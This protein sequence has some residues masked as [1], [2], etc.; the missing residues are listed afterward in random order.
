M[1]LLMGG[2]GSIL[3]AIGIA[4][5]FVILVAL[6]VAVFIGIAVL[7]VGGSTFAPA[8][9]FALLFTLGKSDRLIISILIFAVSFY[10][11]KKLIQ[12]RKVELAI[13]AHLAVVASTIS[14]YSIRMAI[15]FL[16]GHAPAWILFVL[17]FGTMFF[18]LT[19]II[20]SDKQEGK[21]GL[22]II[23]RVIASVLYG[24]A[25]NTLLGSLVTIFEINVPDSS[26]LVS[27]IMWAVFSVIAYVLDIKLAGKDLLK[28]AKENSIYKVL[29]TNLEKYAEYI[30][31]KFSK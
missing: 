18:M 16:F 4:V 29:S 27:M 20:V 2:F 24:S 10:V 9:V 3:A 13:I 6:V 22:P 11:I 1:G 28:N 7:I 25:F 21:E 14:T 12:Y 31:K 19:P 17:M 5:I 23:T 26:A 15:S 8:F 30:L